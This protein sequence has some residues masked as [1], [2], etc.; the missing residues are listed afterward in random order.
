MTTTPT[1][2]ERGFLRNLFGTKP[3]PRRPNESEAQFARRI[4]FHD[5][6]L[7]ETFQTATTKENPK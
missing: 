5:P 6:E 3:E 2:E 1:P 7:P 4:L